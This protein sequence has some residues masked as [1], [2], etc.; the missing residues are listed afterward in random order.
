MEAMLLT[1]KTVF[2]FCLCGEVFRSATSIAHRSLPHREHP[3]MHLNLPTQ[4]TPKPRK[5]PAE[6]PGQTGK[7]QQRTKFSNLPT[8]NFYWFFIAPDKNPIGF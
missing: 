3:F 6:E 7:A 2:I 1:E 4:P 5:A 8:V